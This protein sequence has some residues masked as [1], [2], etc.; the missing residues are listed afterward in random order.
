MYACLINR[1]NDVDTYNDLDNIFSF[2][3]K[4]LLQI[5]TYVYPLTS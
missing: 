1:M 3:Y 2:K 5:K 4:Y